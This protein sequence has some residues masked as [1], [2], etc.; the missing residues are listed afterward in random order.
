MRTASLINAEYIKH[1]VMPP[2]ENIDVKF[3]RGNH[4][5]HFANI[6]SEKENTS[7]LISKLN[8]SVLPSIRN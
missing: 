5:P 1:K 8:N 7:V 3:S 2:D 6:Y 4:L